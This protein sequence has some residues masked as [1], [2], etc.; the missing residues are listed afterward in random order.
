[1]IPKDRDRPPMQVEVRCRCEQDF[2]RT[3]TKIIARAVRAYA[4]PQGLR[5]RN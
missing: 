1:M 4:A 5:G 2:N 3:T